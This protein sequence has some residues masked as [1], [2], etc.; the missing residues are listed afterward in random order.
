MAACH[1]RAV[2]HFRMAHATPQGDFFEYLSMD[3]WGDRVTGLDT[4]LILF[5]HTHVQGMRTF[6]KTIVVNPG[7]VGLARDQ[8]GK[9]CYAVFQDS[10]MRL[11]RIPYDVERT[12][13]AMR[14]APL[15]NQVIEGL[16]AVLGGSR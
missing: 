11:K 7:S 6:E 13:A 8:G 4:D 12:M 16:V 1:G 10:R 2:K 9:A 14:A 3:Q 15:P 5:G